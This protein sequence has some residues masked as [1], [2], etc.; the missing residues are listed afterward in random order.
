MSPAYSL[1][2][3]NIILFFNRGLIFFQMVIFA[4]L[5]RHCPTLSKST[6]KMTSLFRRCLTLFNST[7]KNTT[8]FPE[9]TADLITFTGEILNRKLNFLCRGFTHVMKVMMVVM[10]MKIIIKI[11]KQSFPV[12]LQ[13]RCS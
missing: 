7:L 3:K 9:E 6:L 11:E 10:M 13:N 1:K 2:L 8:L 5:F 4:T 12:V